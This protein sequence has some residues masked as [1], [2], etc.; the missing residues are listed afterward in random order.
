M[1]R[2][3]RSYLWRGLAYG[4]VLEAMLVGAILYWPIFEQHIGVFKSLIPFRPIREA[5]GLQGYVTLQHF[6]KGCNILGTAA[7]VLFAVGAVAGEAQRGT[8]EI[9]LARP[10]SRARLWSER[11]VLG[12][13]AVTVPVFA[14]SATIPWLLT[15][16]EEELALTPLLLSSA[17]QSLFLL[18]VYS[19]TFC[20]S[21]GG[22]RPTVIAFGMLALT[23]FEFSIYLIERVTYWSVF[24]LTDIE[25]FQRIFATGRLELSVCAI[26]VAASGIFAA[27]G[28]LAFR[29]RVP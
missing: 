15:Y 1:A 14:T 20:L 3:L 12:A 9:W 23:V 11:Y 27:V 2:E 5:V 4:I 16:V 25:V 10:V 19:A 18:A 17:H 6:F 22:S 24:R 7:A 21:C 26:L 28:W 8:L 29:R 13:L